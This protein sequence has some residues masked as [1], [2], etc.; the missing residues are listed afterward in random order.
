[1]VTKLYLTIDRVDRVTK[2]Y[3]TVDRVDRVTIDRVDRV[4]KLCESDTKL[5]FIFVETR[6]G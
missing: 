4:T 1:M 6:L 5:R 2:L 3:L